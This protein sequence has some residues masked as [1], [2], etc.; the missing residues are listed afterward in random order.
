MTLILTSLRKSIKTR[1]ISLL[2]EHPCIHVRVI[3]SPQMI[4]RME[5]QMRMRAYMNSRKSITICMR[6]V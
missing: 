4:V 1:Q 3:M 5:K 2:L 6:K